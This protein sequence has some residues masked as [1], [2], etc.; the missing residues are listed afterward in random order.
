MSLIPTILRPSLAVLLAAALLAACAS[1]ASRIRQNEGV[2]NSY[3]PQIQEKIRAGQV[4]IGFTPEMVKLA[5]GEPDRKFSRTSAEGNSEVWAWHDGGPMFSFGVGGGSYG[6]GGFGGG[7]VGVTTGGDQ[8]DDKLRVVFVN[9]LVSS[10][11]KVS[12]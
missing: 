4:D 12:K 2:Y 6:G 8:N 7:G 3:P 11:E 5:L 9:G 1:P 10:I